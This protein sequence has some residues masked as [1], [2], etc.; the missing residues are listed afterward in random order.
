MNQTKPKRMH[1][2]APASWLD[3]V[4]IQSLRKSFLDRGWTEGKGGWLSG[5]DCSQVILPVTLREYR[6]WRNRLLEAIEVAA[7]LDGISAA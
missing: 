6:D 5:P 7:L 1:I 4:D 3:D 2:T